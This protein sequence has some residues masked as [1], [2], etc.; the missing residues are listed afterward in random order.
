ME[1]DNIGFL[2]Q[3]IQIYIGADA[4]ALLTLA[5]VVG[6]D[7]HAKGPGQSAHGFS[8]AAETDDAQRFSGQLGLR[9][10]PVAEA[11]CLCPSAGMDIPVVEANPMAQLQN[12]GHGKL[13]NRGG[14]IAGNVGDGDAPPGAGGAIHHIV[15]RSLNADQADIRAGGQ[16]RLGNGNLVDKHDL[17][18]SDS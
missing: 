1:G 18:V 10:Q 2:E 8:D 17:A 6:Q 16:E 15:S 9:G 7:L 4:S 3:R 11:A 14:S 5:P 12:H 13:G